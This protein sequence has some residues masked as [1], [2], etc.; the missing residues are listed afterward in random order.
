MILRARPSPLR[1]RKFTLDGSVANIRDPKISGHLN[2]FL[3]ASDVENLANLTPPRNAKGPSRIDLDAN[4]TMSGDAVEVRGLHATFGQSTVEASG[5]LKDPKGNGALAFRAD[6]ALGELGRLFDVSSKPEGL[7]SLNGNASLDAADNY[8]VDGNIEAKRVS[9]QQ[10]ARRISNINLTSALQADPHF[11]RLHGLHLTAFG[12]ELLANASL[13]DFH[14]YT[15]DGN[16]RGLD[17]K[18]GLQDFDATLPYDGVLAGNIKVVRRLSAPGTKGI[19]A[20]THLA[21]TPGRKGMPLTGHLNAHYN[22]ANDSLT[23]AD[24]FVSLPHTRLTLNGSLNRQL[25]LALTSRDLSDITGALSPGKPPVNIALESELKLSGILTGSLSA[26]R[27]EG[28]LATGRFSVE[29]RQFDSLGADLGASESGASVRNGNLARSAMQTQFTAFLGLKHWKP[30]P[31]EPIAADVSVRNGD[32]A[33]V[34]VL[35]G[36]TPAG[37][38][39]SLTAS[40]HVQGT[41]GNPQGKV[42]VQTSAGTLGGVAFDQ[43]QAQILLTEQLATIPAAFLQSGSGRADLT[44]EFHHPSKVLPPVNFTRI[45]KPIRWI[46]RRSECRKAPATGN[47]RRPGPCA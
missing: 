20:E 7:V 3:A 13:E 18:R 43:A 27:F 21:I 30:L 46:W 37:Y 15:F 24:S 10:G 14:R 17:L 47:L 22:G 41:V 40:A 34:V 35:A 2:G 45:C 39:G 8:R 1:Y 23:L 9:F 25:S 16:L 44:A 28:H 29:G 12:G 5:M 32:L 4:V 36:G 19:V 11:L 33:D 42:D 6:L 31:R 26:P 38:S